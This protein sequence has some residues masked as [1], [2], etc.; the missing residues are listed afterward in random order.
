MEFED[1]ESEPYENDNQHM[2]NFFALSGANLNV[3]TAHTS[4]QSPDEYLSADG[5]DGAES[6]YFFGQQYQH[7][8][9][10]NDVKRLSPSHAVHLGSQAFLSAPMQQQHMA[11][12]V[13]SDDQL[14]SPQT[15]DIASR[16]NRRPAPLSINGARSY[17]SGIPKTAA[18][19][20]RRAEFGSSMRRVSSAT[21]SGRVSKPV[22][23][24]RS[25]LYDQKADP[26]FHLNRSPNMSGPR[27]TIAP[28]TP[29]TPLVANAQQSVGAGVLSPTF[30]LDEKSDLVA[31]DPTLRTPPTTP[32]LMD[33]LFH[34]NM[35]NGMNSDDDGLA[36]PSLGGFSSD[37]DVPS[38]STAVPGYI[39]NPND[40]PSQPETP[41][42]AGHMGPTY[43]G[44]Q[45][46]NP[47]YNWSDASN[48]AKSSPG[49][50]N[51]HFMN[52]TPS[53][54]HGE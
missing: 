42:Y 37:F 6:E 22:S 43:F 28:P 21:G 41:L 33:N 40:A 54:F 8:L 9:R 10:Q 49:E 13:D 17:A 45:G 30:L 32:G 48:S 7:F 18:D 53:H 14:K 25:P 26:L 1:A 23:M 3:Q 4:V 35:M 12:E 34:L 44:F 47:E 36:T 19:L 27:G 52:M 24:P 50:H 46:G 5:T 2:G 16:R 20:G 31:H 51:V 39:A 11:Y 29:N 15:T 38:M